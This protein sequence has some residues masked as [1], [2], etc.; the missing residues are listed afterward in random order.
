V[1]NGHDHPADAPFEFSAGRL[2]LDFVNTVS[3]HRAIRP[4]ERLHRYAD[5]LAWAHQAGL[6][7]QQEVD[8]LLE[9]AARH[10]EAARQT[11][12][13]A[14]ELRQAL[15][16]IVTALDH[17]DAPD[18]GDQSV[19]NRELSTALAHSRLVPAP[20]GFE[21][22]WAQDPTALDRVLWPV[23]RS[24]A[25]LL[26]TSELAAARE[27]AT[28]TCGWL[29]LDTTK[30]RSRLWCDQSCRNRAKARRRYRQRRQAGGSVEVVN[31]S[32]AATSARGAGCQR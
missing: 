25:D 9:Q 11:F 2:C 20:A 32:V 7:T 10:P 14:L 5:L 13:R 1:S 27:C 15:Y 18:P 30:N 12:E 29:F 28:E 21:W 6:L 23:T 22:G 26:T 17:G 16:R 3:G 8:D 4:R 24:A 19:L 31:G